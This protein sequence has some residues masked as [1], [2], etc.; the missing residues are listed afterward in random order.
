MAKKTNHRSPAAEKQA[1]Y[2]DRVRA[3]VAHVSVPI[4]RPVVDYLDRERLL[5]Q[6]RDAVDRS[7]IGAA[8]AAAFDPA[9]RDI[10]VSIGA[11]SWSG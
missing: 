11:R 9:R 10:R 6:G 4:T 5:P 1:A 2:R 8:I 7:E 3:G